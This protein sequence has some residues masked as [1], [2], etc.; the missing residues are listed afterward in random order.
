VETVR[1]VVVG[2]L[3]YD[4]LARLDG[5]VALGTDTFT[6]IRAG[7]AGCGANAAAWLAA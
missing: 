7:A 2:D 5:G 1:V 6:R 4:L 3:L